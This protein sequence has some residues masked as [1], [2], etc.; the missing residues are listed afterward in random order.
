MTRAAFALSMLAVVAAAAWSYHVNYRTDA[1]LDR[2][3]AL[4]AQIR[5]E[6]AR[7]A[8]LEVEWAHLNA[9]D[10]LA[11]LVERHND[12]LMLIPLAPDHFDRAANA[13]GGRP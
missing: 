1:A 6:Q 4:R 12:R 11:R 13:P 8:V 10:R 7:I 2:L 5:A 3:E 9:P